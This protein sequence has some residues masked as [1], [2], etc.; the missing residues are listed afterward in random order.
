[1][2]QRYTLTLLT[3]LMV[4]YFVPAGA[5]TKEKATTKK[6]PAK[7]A[8]AQKANAKTLGDAAAKVPAADTTKKGGQNN[9]PANNNSSLAEEIV[10]TTSYKPVLAEAVKIRRNPDLEDKTLYKA[11]VTYAPIDKKL[12]QDNNIRQLEAMK[13]PAE[14]DS[15][16][17]NNFVKAGF[18]SMKT[19]FA[20][21]YFGN[22][23]D[24]AL[25]VGGYFK[26][27]AQG[28]SAINKQNDS[29]QEVGIFGKSINAENTLTGRLT[30]N[31]HQ[32]YFYGIDQDNP[33][34]AFDPA[35]QVFNNIGA[36]GEIAKNYKD[37]ENAFTYAAKF[38]GYVFSN[39]FSAKESNV[40]VSGF[41][42][43]TVKQFYAGLSA[44][45]DFATQKD[46]AYSNNNSI[47]RANP[48]IK[49]QG[50][51]YKIDA[52]VNI[53]KEFG[54]S[55]RFYIFPAAKLEFQ[56][57][58]KYVRL[59]AEAKGDINRASIKDFTDI[60]PF[61]GENITLKNSVDKLDITVGLKGTLAPGLGFKAAI[62]RNSV[63]NLPL[64]VNN[65]AATFN[66]YQVIYDN[67]DARVSGFN[68][69]LDFKAS[70]DVNVY[71]RVEFKDYKMATE[72]QPWNLPKF[73]LTAGTSI[74]IND[75]VDINGS[76]MFRGSAQDPLLVTGSTPAAPVY[77]Q[78]ASFA[79]LSGGAT[80][81]VN[82]QLSVF[83]Q[84]NNILNANSKTWVYYPNYGFNIFGGVGYA[85]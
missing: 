40:V 19:T 16:Q 9:T 53:A 44:S 80:Y 69:E 24:E 60:N 10:V 2:N 31:R 62:Y 37:E 85:F 33:P 38:K 74:H 79:D 18:G 70:E 51:N 6:P 46:L 48:Y 17:L 8:A 29:R 73:V 68:G 14:Q 39:A 71:G 45:L 72:A 20:E 36:E 65:F 30:Y 77:T 25:Q 13:R 67:G 82:K 55:S 57:V 54:V 5:Q 12:A 78:V 21:G 28:G 22:G 23:K 81:K 1:M 27:L 56:V 15:A 52:G 3:L 11:P 76:L 35:K 75:K 63:K 32:T 83:V 59:F 47:V 7:T 84:A 50:E 61:L 49:F 4:L 34:V 41:L 66:K 43:K 58:P 26:H 42:N 64:F